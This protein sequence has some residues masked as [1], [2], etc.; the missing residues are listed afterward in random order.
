M[1][2]TSSL[3]K[4]SINSTAERHRVVEEVKRSPLSD[5]LLY[6]KDGKQLRC[7]GYGAKV[8]EDKT[9]A[10]RARALGYIK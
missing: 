1:Q 6:I 10:A 2:S 5:G 9:E 3:Y 4:N 8:D 7:R